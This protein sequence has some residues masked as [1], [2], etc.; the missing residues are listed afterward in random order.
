MA[1][2]TQISGAGLKAKRP[3][4]S[5]PTFQKQLPAKE[6]SQDPWRSGLG[7]G[8]RTAGEKTLF[9]SSLQGSLE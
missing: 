2:L 4:A 5:L 9:A 8:Q 3:K 1:H 7:G 6:A